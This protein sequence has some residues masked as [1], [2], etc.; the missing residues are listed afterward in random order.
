MHVCHQRSAA[1]DRHKTHDYT[2]G[3]LAPYANHIIRGDLLDTILIHDQDTP[4]GYHPGV[5]YSRICNEKSGLTCLK[6]NSH[7]D[8]V[9]L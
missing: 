4:C 2:I 8:K 6:D 5:V 9:Q 3:M 1:S 7:Q